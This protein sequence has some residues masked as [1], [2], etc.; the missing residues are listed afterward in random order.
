MLL[1]CFLVSLL[2][3]ISG[4]KKRMFYVD[5]IPHLVV[6]VS[7]RNLVAASECTVGF[8]SN[9]VQKVFFFYKMLARKRDFRENRCRGS[10]TLHMDVN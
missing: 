3:V 4:V 9:V 7:T 10:N 6:S 2:G 8:S 5:T 1:L